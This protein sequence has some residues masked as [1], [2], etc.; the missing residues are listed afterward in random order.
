MP[1]P[2]ILILDVGKTN[3]KIIVFD[4]CYRMV[5]EENMHLPETTDEDGFPCEDI[6][7]LTNWIKQAVASIC[8]NCL[9]DVRAINFSAYGA[10][11]VHLDEN[12]ELLTPLYNY[13][14][15]YPPQLQKKFY[16]EYGGESAFARKTAS[17]VLGNLNSGMQLYRLKYEKPALFSHIKYSLH[18]PQ[19]LSFL[20]CGK[21]TTDI[22]SVGCHTGLWDF[23]KNDYHLWVSKENILHL[24]SGIHPSD[25]PVGE[26][27]IGTSTIPVGIGLHDSSAALIP[28]LAE[29]H[30]PFV[31]LSTGTW[32]ISLNPFNHL[33]LTKEELDQDCLCYLSYQGKPVK[34]SRLFAGYT[35]EQ[36]TKRLAEHF[37]K[38]PEYFVDVKCDVELLDSLQKTN[39]ADL[40]ENRDLSSFKNYETAYHQLILDLIRLQ[41]ISTRLVLKGSPVRR[42][43]VD[44]GFSKNSIYMHLLAAS[45]PEIKIIAASVPQATSLGAALSIHKYWNKRGVPHL[46]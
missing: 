33:P 36:Q 22:T 4:D 7:A 16:D 21:T 13:L 6:D 30:E 43:F 44:G 10:S 15:P 14:K 27:K 8:T 37:K 39:P 46:I 1:T 12:Y 11:F 45:F 31:L 2:V 35:H 29:F 5:H 40:F 42:I 24:F 3:K 28:Y 26:Y 34:A 25:E 18:L 32:C 17:P 23:D 38:S 9:Y 41:I 20:I 19:F